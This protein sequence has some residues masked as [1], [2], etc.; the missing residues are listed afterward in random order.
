MNYC[1]SAVV[2]VAREPGSDSQPLLLQNLLFSP[3]AAWLCRS[4]QLSGVERFFVVTEREFLD[5]CAACFPQTAHILPYDHPQLNDALQAFVSVAEGKVLTFTQ[6]VWL[7]FAAGQELA[8]AETLLPA[9]VPLGIYRVEP[10]A[11]ARDGIDAAFQGEPYAPA[12]DAAPIALPF[13]TPAERNQA[14]YCARMDNL[15]R[16]LSLGV[17]M[18]DMNAV[19]IDIDAEI[20]SGT[21][22]LPGTILRGR[23]VIGENCE[24]GPN[25][26]IRDCVLGN[27]CVANASQLNQAQF[28]D[29]VNI[30]PFAY[31]RPGS[32]VGDGCKVGDFV[33]LKNSTLGEGTKL[34]HLIY[35]GD[36]DVGAHCN[37]GCG[38]IT[39]NYDGN[40]KYRTTVGDDAFIGCNTNLVSPCQVGDGAYT[41]AGTTITGRIPADA[42]AIGRV[43]PATKPGWARRHRA[44]KTDP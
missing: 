31:V 5:V 15:C 37:F 6:P 16:W 44:K 18:L 4:L 36:S 23:T 35:V 12:L 32:V 3:A 19:Y 11:L 13:H 22:L 7:S 30:G 24:I 27:G 1:D 2:F 10:E 8:Q 40:Y 26:M 43:E 41:A 25:S 28:G 39:C 21:V 14:Q 34:P 17:E 20:G 38:S 9:G 29:N 42:L 33:E